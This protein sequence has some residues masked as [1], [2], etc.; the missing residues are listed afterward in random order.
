MFVLIFGLFLRRSQEFENYKKL[1]LF[2]FLIKALFIASSLQLYNN[3]IYSNQALF[4]Q[5]IRN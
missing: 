4:S 5:K 1:V 3:D 2:A